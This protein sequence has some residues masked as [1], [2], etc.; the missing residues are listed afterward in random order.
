MDIYKYINDYENDADKLIY[1]AFFLLLF[2]PLLYLGFYNFIFSEIRIEW[3]NNAIQN[4]F[5]FNINLE[6]LN[7]FKLISKA[8][9]VAIIINLFLIFLV[10]KIVK[11]DQNKIIKFYL[12]IY[13]ISWP[14]LKISTLMVVLTFLFMVVFLFNNIIPPFKPT[15]VYII[16]MAGS[17]FGTLGAF[18]IIINIVYKF[19]KVPSDEISGYCVS[20]NDQPKLFNLIKNCSEKINSVFP[21]NII[22]GNTAGFFVTSHTLLIF[23]D[24]YERSCK[25]NSLYIPLVALKVLTEDELIGI[26]GHELAHFSGKD[27]L[28]SEKINP[29]INSLKKKLGLIQQGFEESASEK[30]DK[31]AGF[32]YG[33]TRLFLYMILNP[34]IFII[35]NIIKKD[36]KVSVNQ[37]L[38]ADK[39]GAGICKNKKSFITGLCKFC[40]YSLIWKSI[41]E[42]E[43]FNKNKKTLTAEFDKFFK[44]YITEFN[45]KNDLK[46]IMD[47]Q[48]LHPSDT[49]PPIYKRA[50][51]LKL[52]ANDIK[53]SDLIKTSP[54]S[55]NFIINYDTLDKKLTNI[56]K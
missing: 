11:L 21:D 28:Y 40:V 3:L 8:S 20:I 44:K 37:E 17:S 7:Y 32:M 1:Q 41:D 12:P 19:D 42:S 34:V 27:T 54:S 22:I 52:N 18:F 16:I 26:I 49:H 35:I 5:Y 36:L 47:Y 24:E 33:F 15:Q 48:M 38:R 25:G 39:I 23:N 46:Y 10:N 29:V 55:S 45:P 13:K 9:I 51:N 53:K 56:F 30:G 4:P 2:I 6:Y 43:S 50:K 14:V 31:L